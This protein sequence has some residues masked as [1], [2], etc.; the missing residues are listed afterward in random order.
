MEPNQDRCLDDILAAMQTDEGRLL[1]LRKIY[2]PG[3][4][5]VVERL[6]AIDPNR[7]II[8]KEITY[9]REHSDTGRFREMAQLLITHSFSNALWPLLASKVIEWGDEE[10]AREYVNRIVAWEQGG[11]ESLLQASRVAEA[12]GWEEERREYLEG[13]VEKRKKDPHQR[14]SVA[15]KLCELLR[16]DEAI[17]TICGADYGHLPR[18]MDIAEKYAKQKVRKV[19][20]QGY[21]RFREDDVYY[22]DFYLMCANV[23]DRKDEARERVMELYRRENI[24]IERY[25][26]NGHIYTHHYLGLIK[27][28]VIL[29]EQ[30]TAEKFV[31]NV[32]QTILQIDDRKLP[33]PLSVAELY[34]AIGRRERVIEIYEKYLEK[35]FDRPGLHYR[36]ANRNAMIEIL[37]R[38]IEMTHDPKFVVRQYG[39]LEECGMYEKA[40]MLANQCGD[41]DRATTYQQMHKQVMVTRGW[42]SEK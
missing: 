6:L 21:N 27:A 12:Y 25:V 10:T 42:E 20:L 8:E 35:Y 16:F 29:G 9:A 34:F 24:S 18:A 23:L 17:E 5:A 40:A 39:L 14:I 38:A 26:H 13:L 11:E 7:Y 32:K 15:Q 3:N 36:N 37:D 33:L 19:A 2:V 4:A 30:E 1:F 28:L 41:D 31:E 22:V